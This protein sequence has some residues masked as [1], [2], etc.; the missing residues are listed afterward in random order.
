MKVGVGRR[1]RAICFVVFIVII[2]G[3]GEGITENS[4]QVYDISINR[5]S[6]TRY[7][8][9]GLENPVPVAGKFCE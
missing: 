6:P 2:A 3:N 5:D 9:Q 1:L 4:G 7:R 8:N